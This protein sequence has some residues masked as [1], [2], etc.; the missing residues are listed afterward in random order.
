M[1]PIPVPGCRRLPSSPEMRSDS[2]PSSMHSVIQAGCHNRPIAAHARPGTMASDQTAILGTPERSRANTVS[3]R[4]TQPG[5]CPIACLPGPGGDAPA[6]SRARPAGADLVPV[7]ACAR[8][9]LDRGIRDHP[10][11]MRRV[12]RVPRD[13]RCHW[14]WC[15]EC[16]T[17]RPAGALRAA[18]AAGD[19][20]QMARTTG[21]ARHAASR[22]TMP[23]GHP[24]IDRDRN[25]GA[26]PEP[27][28][29]DLRHDRDDSP[30]S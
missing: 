4:R 17:A 20:R 10:A 3:C 23:S 9:G 26:A 2:G 13:T 25:H 18:R 7:R 29:R 8:C 5:T 11:R 12:V 15:V 28:R 24:A 21:S 1:P 22:P 14:R 16:R 19:L 6:P 27:R 30:T